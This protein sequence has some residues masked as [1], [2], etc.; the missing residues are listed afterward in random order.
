M[1]LVVEADLGV[2]D[3]LAQVPVIEGAGG[4]VSDWQGRPATLSSGDKI[5]AAGDRRLHHEVL[6][7]L[8]AD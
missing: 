7:L 1:D 8:A 4:I 5:L 2:Y 3:Y 6:G